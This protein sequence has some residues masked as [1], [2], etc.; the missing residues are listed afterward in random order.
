MYSCAE[1]RT[2]RRKVSGD[3]HASKHSFQNLEE[4]VQDYIDNR[5]HRAEQ[6]LQHFGNQPDLPTAI[7]AATLAID[8]GGKR[9]P[10]QRRIP[11]EMLEHFRKGLSH[12]S[13]SLG[14]CRTFPEL[15]RISEEVAAGIW[16]N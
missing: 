11:G 4:I 6:D 13:K 5:R 9:H 12:K 15:M 2:R 16:K 1:P 14:S 7:R 8:K 3:C 10:H